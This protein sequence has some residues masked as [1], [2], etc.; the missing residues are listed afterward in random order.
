[1]YTSKF[2]E[3]LYNLMGNNSDQMTQR[4]FYV[5][6]VIDDEAFSVVDEGDKQTIVMD[7]FTITITPNR[8]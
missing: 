8:K 4:Q 2:A 6:H 3:D 7:D 1:M 5:D